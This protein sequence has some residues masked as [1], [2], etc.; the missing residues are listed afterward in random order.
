MLNNTQ[1]YFL[2]ISDSDNGDGA[3]RGDLQML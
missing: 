3:I 1:A 2:Q